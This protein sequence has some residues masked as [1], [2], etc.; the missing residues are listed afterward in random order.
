MISLTIS[1]DVDRNRYFGLGDG[2]YDTLYIQP[3]RQFYLRMPAQIEKWII[4]IKKD[5]LVNDKLDGNLY[6]PCI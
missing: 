1:D 4:T 5:A 3:I 2:L 6:Q